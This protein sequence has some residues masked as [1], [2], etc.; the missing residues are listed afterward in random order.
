MLG[1]RSHRQVWMASVL[2]FV[3]NVNLLV[4]ILNGYRVD[5]TW[6]SLSDTPAHV[7]ALNVSMLSN[8]LS[9]LAADSSIVY[10]IRDVCLVPQQQKG[11]AELRKDR[12]VHMIPTPETE[13]HINSVSLRSE[14]RSGSPPKSLCAATKQAPC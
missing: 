12:L 10:C 4:A 7:H 9:C 2:F 11:C 3:A 6:R 1:W 14:Q 5:K 13:T 8:Q